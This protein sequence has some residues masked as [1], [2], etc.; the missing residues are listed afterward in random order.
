M[1]LVKGDT[2]NRM[3]VTYASVVHGGLKLLNQV[4]LEKLTLRLLGNELGVQAAAL[5]WHVANKQALLDAMA[6]TLLAEGTARM[7]LQKKT[8]HWDKRVAA[9][10]NGLRKTLLSCRDGARMVSGTRLSDTRYL[11][12]AETLAQH[13]VDA[14]FTLRQTVVLISTVYNYTLSF[15]MEEQAVYP[16]PG[17]RSPQ[18]G[19]Q[20]RDEW[21]GNGQ[22]PLMRQAGPILFDGFDRRYREGL[23]L[24]LRGAKRD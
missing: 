19:V 11:H 21:L 22:L 3:K 2:L 12:T 14:G 17:Q 15:V 16:Q 23:E 18:Y 10:G 13:V 20:Q 9:F 4:G 7:L 1:G 5:L 8:A 24:I 6:S